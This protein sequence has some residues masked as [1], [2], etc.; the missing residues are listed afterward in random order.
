MRKGLILTVFVA[1]Q[2]AAAATAKGQETEITQL[3]LNIEKLR[4][5]R[6]ILKQMKQG[7]DIL[8]GGYNTVINIAK[9]NFQI[10][11][12][13]L[14]GLLQVNP[15]VRNYKRSADII[16]LQ[17]QL[18][19]EYKKAHERFIGSGVFTAEELFYLGTVYDNLFKQSLRNLDELTGV[20]TAGKMRMSDDERIKAIDSIYEDMESKLLFLRVFNTETTALAIQRTKENADWQKTRQLYLNN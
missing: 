9:G 13:F 7:Y 12:D 2:F 3:A 14:D 19:K 18:V 1:L 4:Q 16:S 6:A 8:T 20:L 11:K 10:H 5:F 15:A 17:V